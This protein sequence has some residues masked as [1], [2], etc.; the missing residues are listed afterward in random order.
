MFESK[1]SVS[2]NK[3]KYDDFN[4]TSKYVR[5]NPDVNDGI[6]VRSKD[7][8]EVKTDN[9]GINLHTSSNSRVSS[10]GCQNVPIQ[11]YLHFMNEIRENNGQSNRENSKKPLTIQY[12][13]TDASKIRRQS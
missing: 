7:P 13:L 9:I 8:N 6:L 3:I 1:E 11:Q 5:E 10:N 12:V 2:I 4:M